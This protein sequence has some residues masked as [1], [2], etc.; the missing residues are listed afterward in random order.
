MKQIQTFVEFNSEYIGKA[1]AE[2]MKT[3]PAHFLAVDQVALGVS[4]CLLQTS[5]HLQKL[6]LKASLLKRPPTLQTPGP[7][8]FCML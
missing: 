4:L 1:A 3:F 2:Q 6:S 5:F 8:S 7:A